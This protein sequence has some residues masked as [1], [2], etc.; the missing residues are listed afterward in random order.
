MNDENRTEIL[1]AI[2]RFCSKHYSQHGRQTRPGANRL[3][4]EHDWCD[5]VQELSQIE[6]GVA[7]PAGVA[8][9]IRTAL[10]DQ[11]PNDERTW[12]QSVSSKDAHEII[13]STILSR[14]ARFGSKKAD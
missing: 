6:Y 9:R 11:F 4:Y 1:E 5:L 12:N 3:W 2:K 8:E 13:A 10:V 7:Q 14:L